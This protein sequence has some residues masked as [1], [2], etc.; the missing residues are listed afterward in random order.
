MKWC[1]GEWRDVT[2]N[3]HKKQA[4]Q[5][6]DLPGFWQRRWP[7]GRFQCPAFLW[8]RNDVTLSQSDVKTWSCPNKTPKQECEFLVL[9]WC[10]GG[11]ALLHYQAYHLSCPRLW[12]WPIVSHLKLS[13]RLLLSRNGGSRTMPVCAVWGGTTRTAF[14]CIHE[15][16]QAWQCNLVKRLAH[17]I[18]WF[19]CSRPAKQTQQSDLPGIKN[20][21]MNIAASAMVVFLVNNCQKKAK[22]KVVRIYIYIYVILYIYI[23]LWWFFESLV[24][25][26]VHKSKFHAWRLVFYMSKSWSSS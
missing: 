3:T 22:A 24:H 21:G 9:Q 8:S 1:R 19:L 23:W 12:L 16:Y 7:Q 6:H 15:Q 17:L 25:R 2:C 4:S 26:F 20:Q 13:I 11:L 5:P 18:L 14:I 10:R